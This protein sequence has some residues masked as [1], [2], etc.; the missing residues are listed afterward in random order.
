MFG[1]FKRNVVY[2]SI[3]LEPEMRS[4]SPVVCRSHQTTLNVGTNFVLIM[5]IVENFSR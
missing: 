3:F 5:W 1:S 2:I 4:P